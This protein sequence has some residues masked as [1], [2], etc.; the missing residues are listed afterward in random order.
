MLA[1]IGRRFR[2]DV[3]IRAW[4]LPPKS[5]LPESNVKEIIESEKLKCTR[6]QSLTIFNGCTNVKPCVVFMCAEK[7][8]YIQTE[9]LN[10]GTTTTEIRQTNYNVEYERAR[11]H[12]INCVEWE[13]ERAMPNI[14]PFVYIQQNKTTERHNV[15][16]ERARVILSLSFAFLGSARLCVCVWVL[17]S[18]YAC[19]CLY[20]RCGM[21]RYAC[22]SGRIH[23]R[24]NKCHILHTRPNRINVRYKYL[25]QWK[26]WK[27][28]QFNQRWKR[29]T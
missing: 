26:Y 12:W 3:T 10:T 8:L 25:A 28:K 19:V 7:A 9:W 24:A 6:T 5:A 16:V 2:R 15:V 18:M 17:L 11:E 27:R 13:R 1:L 21:C 22:I 29:A 23:V 4:V 20:R 14:L